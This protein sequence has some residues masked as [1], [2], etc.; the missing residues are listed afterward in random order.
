MR[1]D[2]LVIPAKNGEHRNIPKA[3]FIEKVETFVG[4]CNPVSVEYLFKELLQY[5]CN[6]LTLRMIFALSKDGYGF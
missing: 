1:M 3:K 4:A 5:S 2:D 6:I